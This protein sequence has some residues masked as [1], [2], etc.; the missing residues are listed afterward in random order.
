MFSFSKPTHNRPPPPPTSLFV[1]YSKLSYGE[2]PFILYHLHFLSPKSVNKFIELSFGKSENLNPQ[3]NHKL[4][5][6]HFSS[7][8]HHRATT[9]AHTTLCAPPHSDRRICVSPRRRPTAVAA[10]SLSLLFPSLPLSRVLPL[11]AAVAFA[12]RCHRNSED[13]RRRNPL[14]SLLLA[15]VRRRPCRLCFV[16]APSEQSATMVSG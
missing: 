2:P 16:P 11:R 6:S 12:R 15:G 4:F 13:R 3:K 10:L 1:P 5:S 9:T 7:S 8:R 14:P